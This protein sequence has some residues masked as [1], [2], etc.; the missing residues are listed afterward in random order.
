M[1]RY[2]TLC[3]LLVCAVLP[4][5]I[6]SAPPDRSGPP[7][8]LDQQKEPDEDQRN[9]FTKTFLVAMRNHH[10]DRNANAVREFFDPRYLKKH[11]LT[12]RDLSATL[13]PVRNIYSYEYADD[14]QTILCLVD[15]D[16]NPQKPVREIILLRYTVH[17]GKMY[18][19]P[20]RAPD[21]KTGVIT[22]WI[23][24]TKASRD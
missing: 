21:P 10:G 3:T 24:R 13:A 17:E 15:T 6:W 5:H 1:I 16:A 23:L 22:P 4:T 19:T 18:L 14:K 2:S 8:D 11:G 20:A 7:P 12:D 9:V